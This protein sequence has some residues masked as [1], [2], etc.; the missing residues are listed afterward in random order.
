MAMRERRTYTFS[1][2]SFRAILPGTEPL[3]KRRRRGEKRKRAIIPQES[4]KYTLLSETFKIKFDLRDCFFSQR[5]L[6]G[7][8]FA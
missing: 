4:M 7:D 5:V 8:Y 3:Q 1:S 2:S 6:P